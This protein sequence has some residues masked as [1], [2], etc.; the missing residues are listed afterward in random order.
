MVWGRLWVGAFFFFSFLAC[1]FKNFPP[2]QKNCPKQSRFGALGSSKI[3]LIC[4]SAKVNANKRN[5][6]VEV[7]KN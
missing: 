6:S 3:N 4:C 1:F 2:A 7:N 5:E